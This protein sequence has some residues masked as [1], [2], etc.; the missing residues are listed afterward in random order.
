MKGVV[1]AEMVL[2]K[3]LDILEIIDG[4]YWFHETDIRWSDIED[5]VSFLESPEIQKKV[6]NNLCSY[7]LR[8]KRGPQ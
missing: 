3:T 6:E 2:T 5:C 1:V 4:S 7:K 8:I